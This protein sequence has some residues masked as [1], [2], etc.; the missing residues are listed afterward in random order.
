METGIQ[1]ITDEKG[2]KKSVILPLEEYERLVSSANKD[3]RYE[4]IPYNAGDYDG[5]TIPHDVVSIMVDENVSLLTAWRL[6]RRLTQKEVAELLGV[7]QSAVSQF[8][9]AIVPRTSTL[10]KLAEIYDC[11]IEQLSD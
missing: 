5:E 11:R 6:Y 7:T 3:D 8:E 10:E 1:F 9:K 2:I 4:S